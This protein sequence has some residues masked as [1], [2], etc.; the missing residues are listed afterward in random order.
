MVTL[1]TPSFSER[2]L[3]S[4]LL[5][6]SLFVG[7]IRRSRSTQWKRHFV[8]CFLFSSFT[9]LSRRVANYLF[10]FIFFFLLPCRPHYFLLRL[11]INFFVLCI[12]LELIQNYFFSLIY[13]RVL[14][15]YLIY[16][17][18]GVNMTELKIN[19]I[20]SNR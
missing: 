8:F 16:F 1:V 9:R 15:K 18:G 20:G 7:T 13:L 17:V 11:L 5:F 6:F 12:L 19:W 2:G 14:S 10:I 3:E 4:K